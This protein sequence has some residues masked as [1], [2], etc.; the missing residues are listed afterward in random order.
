VLGNTFIEDVPPTP[1][2]VLGNTFIEDVF[3]PSSDSLVFFV[4][5]LVKLTKPVGRFESLVNYNQHLSQPIDFVGLTFDVVPA[6]HWPFDCAS[7]SLQ[8]LLQI[9]L[10]P[11][12]IFDKA[13]SF[14]P[15]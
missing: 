9:R 14:S 3:T 10:L 4:Q 13:G 2:T 11:T 6:F 7:Q 1:H 12:T 8:F 15:D 5:L